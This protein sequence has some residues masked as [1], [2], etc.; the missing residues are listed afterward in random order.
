MMN[1]HEQ[2][3]HKNIIEKNNLIN[4]QQS[5]YSCNKCEYK[6][7]IQSM[8]NIHENLKHVKSIEKRDYMC[9]FCDYETDQKDIFNIHVQN[10][11]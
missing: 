10:C 7:D 6:T 4:N 8:L 3:K 2:T 5:T 11:D 1:A 9:Y